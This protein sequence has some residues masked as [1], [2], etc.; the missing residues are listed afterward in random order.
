[1]SMDTGHITI[2]ADSVRWHGID[3]GPLTVH[4]RTHSHLIL[5]A[6]GHKYWAG[7]GR[8]QNYSGARFWVFEI[9]SWST[10]GDSHIYEVKRI[11]DFPL[12]AGT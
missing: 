4:A 6:A 9:L 2:K 1:M 3:A 11:V 8:P 12:K 10:D 5:K 7:I